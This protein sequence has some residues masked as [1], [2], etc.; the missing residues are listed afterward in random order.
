[1][2]ILGEEIVEVK[3]S[4]KRKPK[5]FEEGF[6]MIENRLLTQ[7][8]HLSP[9]AK[10]AY[11][12]TISFMNADTKLCYPRI[13]KIM[14]RS[15]LTKTRACNALAELEE[16]KWVTKDKRFSGSTYYTFHYPFVHELNDYGETTGLAP[17]QTCPTE[18]QASLW[19]EKLKRKRRAGKTWKGTVKAEA[20]RFENEEKDRVEECDIPF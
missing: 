16:F 2:D 3:T 10:V 14:E 5:T 15:G 11:W 19:R 1:M 6:T 13:E 18:G 12:A 20:L 7:G 4:A 8:R 17:D 9:D